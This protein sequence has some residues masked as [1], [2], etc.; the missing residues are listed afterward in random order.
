MCKVGL[1][2]LTLGDKTS[3][4]GYSIHDRKYVTKWVVFFFFFFFFLW[5]LGWAGQSQIGC[6]CPVGWAGSWKHCVI[7]ASEPMLDVFG[8][9]VRLV[10]SYRGCICRLV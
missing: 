1:D 6:I 8:C 10:K 7:K 5:V 2:S 9:K 4:L 3:K